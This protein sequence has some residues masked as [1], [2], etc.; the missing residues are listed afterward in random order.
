[1]KIKLFILL[2]IGL[3][4][5]VLVRAQDTNALPPE[6]IKILNSLKYQQGQIDL[7]NGL[8]T[9][10]VP[11]DFNYLG[12][13]DAETVLVKLWGNPP[14]QEKPLGLLIPA[15]MTP[16]SSN[17]WVVTIHY[18]EDGYVKDTDA[19]KIDYDKLLK[20]MQ[21]SIADNNKA[22]QNQGYPPITLVGWAAPPRY[23]AATHKLYWAKDLKFGDDQVDTLN[24]SIRILG[25]RGVLELNAVSALS[26]FNQIDQQTP[27]I[28][29]MVDFKGGNRYAD[30]DP[31]VDKVAK[32]GIAALVAGGVL[33]AAA[34]FGLLKVIW[35][36]ILAMKKFVIIGV[37]AVVAFFKKLFKGRSSGDIP[38]T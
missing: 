25:R 7:K 9:L 24:Y 23:D 3:F 19:S 4:A 38:R 1:M 2:L 31:K 12:P 32:Y 15:G 27:E 6:V 29:G 16:A 21:Q 11:A 18:T 26:Q 36:A 34:K 28:L 17:A 22:R 10:N 8:A 37:L 33:T 5:N 14:S 13:D 35:V 30:F 20:Q